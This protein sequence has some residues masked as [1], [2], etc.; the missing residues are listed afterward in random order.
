MLYMK[1]LREI[2]KTFADWKEE[3]RHVRK[4]E[5]AELKNEAG[6]WCF[7]KSQT[8]ISSPPRLFISRRYEEYPG[9]YEAYGIDDGL[10]AFDIGADF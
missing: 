10:T 3:G 9:D 4:G 1:A 7:E 8:E 2:Y 5:H 6:E